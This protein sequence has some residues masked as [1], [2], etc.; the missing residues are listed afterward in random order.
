MEP[1]VAPGEQRAG[2]RGAKRGGNAS[3]ERE[4]R[5]RAVGKEA[6]GIGGEGDK[7]PQ[8]RELTR[9]EPVQELVQ[10]PDVQSR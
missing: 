1:F 9:R 2:A 3:S 10:L 6:G 4:P 5:A 7:A 8:Q